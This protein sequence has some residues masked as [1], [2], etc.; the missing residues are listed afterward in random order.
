MLD[1]LPFAGSGGSRRSAGDGLAALGPVAG[2][3]IVLLSQHP[4]PLDGLF[5]QAA[6]GQL[7]NAIGQPAF[8]E[9][10]VIG[11][12]LG[13]EQCAPFGLQGAAR[14]ALQGGQLGQNGI[15]HGKP[16]ESREA[17]HR[18]GRARSEANFLRVRQEID[19]TSR[20]QDA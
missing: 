13:V 9:A 10:P 11:R 4:K 15:S 7:L 6:I 17:H 5:L 12:R 19:W 8:Q 3:A 18:S 20:A 2:L 1:P 14:R 16:R